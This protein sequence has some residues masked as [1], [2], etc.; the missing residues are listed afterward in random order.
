MNRHDA[1]CPKCN[2]K[3]MSKDRVMGSDTGDF[4][5]PNPSCKYTDLASKFLSESRE[6]D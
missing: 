5:C 1:I 4:Q 6:D 2:T 3:G